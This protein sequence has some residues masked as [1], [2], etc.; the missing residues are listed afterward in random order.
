[1]CTQDNPRLPLWL[2]TL[3]CLG[4]VLMSLIIWVKM[5]QAQTTDTDRVHIDNLEQDMMDLNTEILNARARVTKFVSML[6]KS[7][8][9][10]DEMLIRYNAANA[11]WRVVN[12]RLDEARTHLEEMRSPQGKQRMEERV[13]TLEGGLLIHSGALDI[14]EKETSRLVEEQVA[15]WK[16]LD[17]ELV[18]LNQLLGDYAR[19]ESDYHR[20][21]GTGKGGLRHYYTPASYERPHRSPTALTLRRRAYR[22]LDD[23]ELANLLRICADAEPSP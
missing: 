15:F 5:A 17:A 23:S 8:E 4:I 2:T 3:L 18:K 13:A 20:L 11:E 1:M 22:A 10:C 14:V 9:H 7:E 19:L 16:T 12:A 6:H 21:R